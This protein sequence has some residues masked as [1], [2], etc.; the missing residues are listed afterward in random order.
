MPLT[1]GLMCAIVL[2]PGGANGVAKKLKVPWMYA[3]ADWAG[4]DLAPCKRFKVKLH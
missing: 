4:L 2:V 3:H 1:A